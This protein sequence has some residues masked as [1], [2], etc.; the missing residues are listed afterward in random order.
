MFPL[1]I[2]PHRSYKVKG[3]HYRELHPLFL[4]EENTKVL[5]PIIDLF[6]KALNEKWR[7][8]EIEQK[9]KRFKKQLPGRKYSAVKRTLKDFFTFQEISLFDFVPERTTQELKKKGLTTLFDLELYLYQIIN[10]QYNGYLSLE[11][12][13]DFLKRKSLEFDFPSQKKLE[14]ALRLAQ[15]KNYRMRLTSDELPTSAL[16]TQHYHYHILETILMN[17]TRLILEKKEKTGAFIKDAIYLCKK[18]LLDFNIYLYQKGLQKSNKLLKIEETAEQFAAAKKVTLQIEGPKEVGGSPKDY[19][20]HLKKFLLELLGRYQ[21]M[22]IEIHL[23]IHQKKCFYKLRKKDLTIIKKSIGI[24]KKEG[25]V[26]IDSK[27]EAQF[28]RFFGTNTAG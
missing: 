5:S 8:D 20:W 17:S 18:Y 19:S 16:I 28:Q 2:F 25:K 6:Q 10:E 3:H 9:L 14:E 27:I 15:E 24:V 7:Q 13:D 22:K 1:S 23:K 21:E 11:K 4:D 12:R 26:D